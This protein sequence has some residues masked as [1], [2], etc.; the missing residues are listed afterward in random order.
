MLC[1]MQKRVER[2]QQTYNANT[3]THTHKMHSEKNLAIEKNVNGEAFNRQTTGKL[4][5][6]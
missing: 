3:H 4:I 6:V 5:V 2:N 1:N